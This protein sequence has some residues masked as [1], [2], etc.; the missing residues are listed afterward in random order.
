[1][2]NKPEFNQSELQD[3]IDGGGNFTQ[4]LATQ[5][6]RAERKIEKAYDEGYVAGLDRAREVIANE[7]GKVA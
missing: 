7:L 1:M 6:L 3:L 2:N 4:Q 5:C